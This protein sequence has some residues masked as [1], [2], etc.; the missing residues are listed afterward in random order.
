MEAGTVGEAAVALVARV[1]G[2]QVK[3]IDVIL[4]KLFLREGSITVWFSTPPAPDLVVRPL[5]IEQ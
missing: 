1:L 5:V 3:A 4:K 2:L